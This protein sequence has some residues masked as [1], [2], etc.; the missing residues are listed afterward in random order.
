MKQVPF[1]LDNY[2][3]I[4]DWK[5][6]L[7]NQ[8]EKLVSCSSMNSEKFV[9]T[10]FMQKSL[11]KSHFSKLLHVSLTLKSFFGSKIFVGRQNSWNWFQSSHS[12]HTCSNFHSNSFSH[13]LQCSN[14]QMR[15][16]G[17]KIWVYIVIL[18]E[19]KLKGHQINGSLPLGNI[20]RN[21]SLPQLIPHSN[22]LH[23]QMNNF[24]LPYQ[25]ELRFGT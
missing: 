11:S 17:S 10:G 2:F 22:N 4:F 7:H 25:I 9:K 3:L 15:L 5:C 16:E 20:T 24:G 12:S 6:V 21:L 8:D 19:G 18:G 14:A 13:D 23:W 1:Y